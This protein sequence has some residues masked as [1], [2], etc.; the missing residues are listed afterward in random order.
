[1]PKKKNP[2]PLALVAFEDYYNLGPHR[3]L[4]RLAREQGY[5]LRMLEEWSRNYGWQEQVEDR[6]RDE[7]NAGRDAARKEQ[8]RMA[9]RRLRNAA[10]L[11]EAGVT[12]IAKA[13]IA[14]LTADEA[15]KLLSEAQRMIKEGI[16][17][18]RME[19]GEPDSRL[20]LTPPKP[21]S[22]MTNEELAAYI[23]LLEADQAHE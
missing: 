13:D 2:S 5:N 11:Q 17:A 8:A 12:I 7:V 10:V 1:M 9:Q 19:I 6:I 18:E 4:A 3:S 20:D 16:R 23:A 14:N 21:L 15:R 22:D